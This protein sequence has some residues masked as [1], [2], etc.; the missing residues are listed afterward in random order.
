AVFDSNVIGHAFT[1]GGLAASTSGTGY[2]IPLQDNAGTPNPV[3]LTVGG[4][5]SST[6]YAG[7]LSGGGSLTKTGTGTLTLAGSN[8][9]GG[10]TTIGGGAVVI[11]PAAPGAKLGAASG[12]L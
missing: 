1:L 3:A 10:G 4:N 12:P 11:S 7:V 8:S 5:N 6:T 2:D 9:Y